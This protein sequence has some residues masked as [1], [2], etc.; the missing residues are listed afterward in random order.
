MKNHIIPL[1]DLTE[2][3]AINILKTPLD[4]L[5]DPSVHYLAASNLAF[6]NS[7]A[8]IEILIETVKNIEK[9]LYDPITRR[10][11][12]ESL[13]KLKATK[14]LSIL[15][16]CLDDDDKYLV[17]I[18]VMAI[19]QIKTND[20][21]ILEKI[22][23][24]LDKSNYNHRKIIQ[25]LTKLNYQLAI[26]KIKKFT[27]SAS[28][29]LASVSIASLARLT[30]DFSNIEKIT[31]FLLHAKVNDRR[32]CI[33]DIID[34]KYYEGLKDIIQCPISIVFRL[35]SLRLMIQS[36]KN[37]N[38]LTFIQIKTYLEQVLRDHVKDLKFISKYN[39]VPN[40][41]FLINELYDTDFERAYLASKYIIEL[42]SEEA[43]A[44]LMKSYQK[45]AY[46]HYNA[47]YHFMKLFG[48]LKYIPAYDLLVNEALKNQSS[49]F[50]KS[51]IAGAIALGEIGEKKVIDELKIILN[52]SLWDLKYA[53]IIA[54]EK[55]EGS[56]DEDLKKETIF[57]LSSRFEVRS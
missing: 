16:N 26:P 50:Q 22:T 38:K 25:A 49:Q 2:K 32:D 19:A 12:V 41:D 56:F 13:G 31:T 57:N 27:T 3:Q 14:S 10:K 33:Q 20:S 15:S 6:Y 17:E 55:L 21:E 8:S 4:K 29:N 7:E 39:K 23:S 40:L 36:D 35:K 30:G 51:R 9:K 43:P 37:Q 46:K 24:L 52:N 11:A 42:Y 1:F 54:L 34:G 28:E 53:C 47:H 18:A 44:L 48:W 45:K 5:V